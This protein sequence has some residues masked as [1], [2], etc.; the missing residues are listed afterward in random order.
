VDGGVCRHGRQPAG[1]RQRPAPV[2]QMIPDKPM[3]DRC[4]WLGWPSVWPWRTKGSSI[5]S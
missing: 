5:G 3:M 2:A 1:G 4:R